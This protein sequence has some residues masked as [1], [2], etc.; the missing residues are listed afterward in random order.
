MLVYTT[1]KFI[2][3]KIKYEKYSLYH[4]EC[5]ESTDFYIGDSLVIACLV[6]R[7]FCAL[8]VRMELYRDE[9]M[10]TRS[11]RAARYCF[12]IENDI[13]TVAFTLSDICVSRCGGHFAYA[14]F[15]QTPYGVL[16]ASSDGVT[17]EAREA[18]TF[19]EF[20]VLA[21]DSERAQNELCQIVQTTENL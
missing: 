20:R 12:D 4:G 9:D 11:I 17:S 21:H 18:V 2:D 6:P 14:F 15:L 16:W 8:G 1:Y 13:F 5:S 19:G 7:E 3:K 10:S